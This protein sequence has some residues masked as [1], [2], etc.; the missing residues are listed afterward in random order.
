L[1]NQEK[2]LIL[3]MQEQ[4][5]TLKWSQRSHQ[6][7][8]T[9]KCNGLCVPFNQHATVLEHKLQQILGTQTLSSFPI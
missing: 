9:A 5:P 3:V 6:T 8:G 4:Q 7:T 1:E 2:P